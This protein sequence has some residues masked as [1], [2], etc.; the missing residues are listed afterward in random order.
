MVTD[1]D[2]H[3]TAHR[4]A[5]LDEECDRRAVP[6]RT[7]EDRAIVI[8]PRRNIETWFEYLDD[9]EVDED[10]TCP[11]RF[12]GREHRHLAEK[13]YRLCHEDQR[14]PESAPA[15]LVESCVDY[16]KLKR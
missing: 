14:L 16:A 5:Q 10:S 11:K 3:A 12:V 13:L 8:V 7:P 9:R 1:A 6:R 2:Q 15:S 4:R